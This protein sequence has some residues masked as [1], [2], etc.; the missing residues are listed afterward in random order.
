MFKVTLK[1]RKSNVYY[2][3]ID[4]LPEQSNITIERIDKYGEENGK[5]IFRLSNPATS[6][7]FDMWA[8]DAVELAEQYSSEL[9]VEHLSNLPE[10]V[11]VRAKQTAILQ[12][13]DMTEEYI[14]DHVDEPTQRSIGLG[15]RNLTK[16]TD[17]YVA[18][19]RAFVEDCSTVCH[20]AM[21]GISNALNVEDVNYI[22]ANYKSTLPEWI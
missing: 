9:Y 1:S 7:R 16:Y 8:L 10:A 5:W 2:Y 11:I 20:S 12:I 19:V 22:I 6:H 14:L 13:V 3:L 21:S 17:E 18:K 4:S 15:R